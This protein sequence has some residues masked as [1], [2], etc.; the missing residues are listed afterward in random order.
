MRKTALLFAAALLTASVGLQA[1]ASGVPADW[2]TIGARIRANPSAPPRQIEVMTYNVKGLPWPVSFGRTAALASIADRLGAMRA[3]G[4]APQVVVLQE[5]FTQEAQAIGARAGYRYQ[6]IGPA[7]GSAMGSGLVI[8][9]DLPIVGV[10]SMLFPAG[11]CAGLDCLASKGAMA[12]RIAVP[13]LTL[14]VEVVTT[15]LNANGRSR[16]PLGQRIRAYA[17]QLAA[18]NGFVDRAPTPVA[19]RIVA[20]DFNVGH[21]EDRLAGLL[22]SARSWGTRAV[23]ALGRPEFT[24]ECSASPASCGG[25]QSIAANVPLKHASDWQ[26]VEGAKGVAVKV[27]TPRTLFALDRADNSLSDH[28]GYSVAYRFQS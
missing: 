28:A 19:A 14:P 4:T 6:A 3:A 7:G 20:G 10:R 15:H 23:A 2:A 25:P 11:A 17:A 16:A 8:L 27:G 26:F 12:A 13:G 9:S 18:L 1:S 5:A 24:P 22:A 21:T